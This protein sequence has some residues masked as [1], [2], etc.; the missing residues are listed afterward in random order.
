[1]LK[2]MYR[3][4]LTFS[5]TSW[6]IVLYGIKQNSTLRNISQLLFCLIL[7]IIPIITSILSLI[8]ANSFSNDNLNSCIDVEYANSSFISIYLGYFFV[9]LS[10]ENITQLIIVYALIFTFTHLSQ[11]E[12]FNPIYLLFSYKFY[13]VTSAEGTKLFVITRKYL[14]NVKQVNF[15]CLKRINETTF[16]ELRRKNNESVVSKN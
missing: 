6:V 8:L 5:A 10:L 9:G 1:M 3:M 11:A 15:E 13:H 16:I 12:Y 14:R 7:L 4:L 2:L